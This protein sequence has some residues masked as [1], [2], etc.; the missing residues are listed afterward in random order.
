MGIEKEP[1]SVVC[2]FS[3]PRVYAY[4]YIFSALWLNAWQPG[5]V[6][7]RLITRQSEI[8]PEFLP[9]GYFKLLKNIK[10]SFRNV[11]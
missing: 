2:R 8:L 6:S 1:R 9:D 11:K 10:W 5:T 7:N 4:S 3:M